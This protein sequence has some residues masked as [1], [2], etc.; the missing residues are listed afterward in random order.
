MDVPCDAIDIELFAACTEITIGNGSIVR[1]WTDNWLS[2]AAPASI[3]PGLFKVAFRKKQSVKD[4]LHMGR[5]MR[6]LNRLSTA[7]YLEDF[8]EFSGKIHRDSVTWIL[9]ADKTY[10]AKSSYEAQFYGRLDTNGRKYLLKDF[11]FLLLLQNRLWTADR[12]RT[13]G[14][15]H[16]DKCCFCSQVLENDEHLV[17]KCPFVKE[18]WAECATTEQRMVNLVSSS[19]GIHDWW[20]VEILALSKWFKRRQNL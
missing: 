6:G 12:L 5:W 15:T 19:I 8:V 16:D 2:G 14:W 17:L 10:S 18:V 7:Q 13:R 3:A 4:A 11:F 1:F 9:T 20:H